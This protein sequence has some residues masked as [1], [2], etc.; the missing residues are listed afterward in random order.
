MQTY[1][2]RSHLVLVDSN[3]QDS[4]R[5]FAE[6]QKWL[7]TQL[8]DPFDSSLVKLSDAIYYQLNMAKNESGKRT[9]LLEAIARNSYDERPSIQIISADLFKDSTFSR[10]IEG[11]STEFFFLSNTPIIQ[12]IPFDLPEKSL[13]YRSTPTQIDGITMV[14]NISAMRRP[15]F[16]EFS[17]RDNLTLAMWAYQLKVFMPAESSIA[18]AEKRWKSL[19]MAD[20]KEF[21]AQQLAKDDKQKFALVE[22]K[23]YRSQTLPST[24]LISTHKSFEEADHAA[25]NFV[26]QCSIVN[27]ESCEFAMRW[28][29]R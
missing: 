24:I 18:D 20:L 14:R 17:Q 12:G 27:L 1:D 9:A 25:V 22:V 5:M 8:L 3:S 13:L 15:L 10:V 19:A 29:G 21:C 28:V 6:F 16:A 2:V 11:W 4:E 23:R 26:S 7:E